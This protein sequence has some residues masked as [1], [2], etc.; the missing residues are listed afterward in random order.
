VGWAPLTGGPD[1]WAN[2]VG[3]RLCSRAHTQG[4]GC[5]W[6][7]HA[8][9]VRGRWAAASE[10]AKGRWASR[11]LPGRAR[12]RMG[13]REG[14]ARWAAKGKGG[15]G[16]SWACAREWAGVRLGRLRRLGKQS[17]FLFSSF[18]FFSFIRISI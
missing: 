11:R 17:L 3:E 7:T 10:W 15:K 14:V 18:L 13:H 9:R 1:G 6:D 8:A 12:L 16:A 4:G 2:G 5:G